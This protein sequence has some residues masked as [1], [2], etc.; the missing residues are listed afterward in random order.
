MEYLD[1][2]IAD[3]FGRSVLVGALSTGIVGGGA[4][5]ILDLDQPLLAVGVPSG[6]VLRPIYFSMSVQPGIETADSHETDAYFGVDSL[7]L[8]TGDGTKTDENPSN[9]NSRLDKGSMCRVGSAF[10]GN[11]TTTPKNGQ[12]AGAPV[13]D[14]ELARVSQ[15]YVVGDATFISHRE[16]KVLYKPIRP[17]WLEGPCT[18]IAD[19]GGS[20]A[21]VGVFITFKWVESSPAQMRHYAG[22]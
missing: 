1:R 8:W 20:I 18:L 12:A 19:A 22:Y 16:V 3:G 21:T 15:T 13:V 7:G 14:M 9:L 10:T 17:E 6:V 4:G 5:T 2:M 11:M